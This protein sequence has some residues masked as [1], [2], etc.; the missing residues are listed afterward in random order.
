MI[1]VGRKILF[2]GLQF[3]PL[4]LVCIWIYLTVQP[5]YLQFVI[6]TANTVTQRLDPP[7]HVESGGTRMQS[8]VFTAE[9][10]QRTLR[11]WS[12]KM[13]HLILLSLALLPALLLATPAPFLKRF[14]LLGIG[15]VLMFL[16]NV[17][18]MIGLTRGYYGLR[19]APGTFYWLWVFRSVNA[20]G[21]FCSAAIWALLTWRYWLPTPARTGA[22]AVAPGK[23]SPS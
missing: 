10:G 16:G 15:L 11:T 6:A 2:F 21:Q 22:K 5:I 3:V 20:S 9:R 7:T 19:E 14:Q 4:F 18:A 8:F 12:P 17:L 23:A 13:G 1:A